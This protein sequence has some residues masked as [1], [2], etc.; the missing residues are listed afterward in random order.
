MKRKI[1]IVIPVFNE[2]V[3]IGKT[4]QEIFNTM[5]KCPEIEEFEIIVVNDGSTDGTKEVLNGFGETIRVISHPE[6]IGYGS[7]LKDG[8]KEAKYELIITTDADGTYPV[9]DIPRLIEYADNYDMV[10]GA[11][12][13]KAYKGG[14]FKYPARKVFKWLCEFT[15]GRKI[16][17]INSG[18]RLFK[19]SK[20]LRF[21]PGI[22]QGF[23]FSTSLT[24]A[25]LLSGCFVKYIPIEY[26]NREGKSKV[27]HFR[28]TLRA[29]QII[30][31]T[32][33]YYNPIKI[34]IIMAFFL[35][36][37]M[38]IGILGW[39]LFPLKWMGYLAISSFLGVIIVLTGGFLAVVIR[40]TFT[41]QINGKC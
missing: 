27:K 2:E 9:A 41:C 36:L 13:G 15:T 38:L 14:I 20:V 34:F 10:V 18:F 11:R 31:E 26:Y 8:I 19:K 17:D 4:I 35:F 28:D 29:S 25:M 6:N 23:S 12:S 7:S 5:N 24:L 33:L 39:L 30:V 22:C 21:L 37:L 1:S 16:P 32:I 3:A 40:K